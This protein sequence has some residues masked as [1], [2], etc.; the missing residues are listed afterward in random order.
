MKRF[1]TALAVLAGLAVMS[2]NSVQ[3]RGP[4]G[5]GGGIG[6]GMNN[7]APRFT[8]MPKPPIS[9]FSSGTGI[10]SG[11]GNSKL[12]SSTIASS[13]VSSLTLASSKL[14]SSTIVNPK[15]TT[16]ANPKLSN[17]VDPKVVNPKFTTI[18]NPKLS[19]I[20]DPKVVKIVNPKFTNLVD[21]KVV[22]P[23][24]TKIIDPK[25]TKIIDPKMTKVVNPKLTD[26]VNPK[27]YDHKYCNHKY[28]NYKWCSPT[29]CCP[30]IPCP[31]VPCDPTLLIPVYGGYV[32]DQV[33]VEG[34]K[35]VQDERFLR[36]ENNTKEKVQ[37]YVQVRTKVEGG[38]WAW[39][40]GDPKT[41]EKAFAFE[42]EAGQVVDLKIEEQQ[43]SAS[44][45]HIWA[46]SE[47]QKWNDF[48]KKD[49]WL[50]PEKDVNGKHRYMAP[51]MQTY[52]YRVAGE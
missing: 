49:L 11:L 14:V 23:K 50:V 20:V 16:V 38:E 31:C 1:L 17:F 39:L 47:T 26:L 15:F 4:G 34:E 18:V 43:L 8:S 32:F 51:T 6:G 19:N 29:W 7:S 10:S 12:V 2:F 13:K 52:L 3:A 22:D 40:P 44:R 25:M 41:E 24:F 35:A 9:T 48:Q 36:V 21:T 46:E 33:V 28:C 30:I 5:F 37:L 27:I 45:V 42:L